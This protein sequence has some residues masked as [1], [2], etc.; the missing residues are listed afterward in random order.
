[1][2]LYIKAKQVC[3]IRSYQ[4]S[5]SLSLSLIDV[6][7]TRELNDII[8]I[9]HLEKKS[10]DGYSSNKYKK[11]EYSVLLSLGYTVLL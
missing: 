10:Y 9:I 7:L 11:K 6:K 5:Y 8:I 3:L 1:M 4:N 2:F